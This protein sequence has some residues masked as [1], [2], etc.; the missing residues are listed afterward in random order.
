MAKIVENTPSSLARNAILNNFFLSARLLLSS[1]IAV[2]I[3]LLVTS[4]LE[5]RLFLEMSELQICAIQPYL[6]L[7]E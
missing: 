2:I 4:K 3:Y 5:I 7:L 1:R 6:Y